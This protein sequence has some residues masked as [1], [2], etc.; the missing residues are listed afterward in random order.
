MALTLKEQYQSV[1]TTPRSV[2]AHVFVCGCVAYPPLLS[3]RVTFY[4]S[5][6]TL[7]V[8]GPVQAREPPLLSWLV[9]TRAAVQAACLCLVRKVAVQGQHRFAR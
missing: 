5:D 3:L 4:D 1:L 9:S 8:R 6:E 2:P 7:A